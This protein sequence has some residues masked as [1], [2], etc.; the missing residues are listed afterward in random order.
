[1]VVETAGLRGL[2]MVSISDSMGRSTTQKV[3]LK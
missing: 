2:Y 3:V 1:V